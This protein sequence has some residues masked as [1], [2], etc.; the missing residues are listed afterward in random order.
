MPSQGLSC[1]RQ[2]E[3]TPNDRVAVLC[4]QTIIRAL[5]P[6]ESDYTYFRGVHRTPRAAYVR[7]RLCLPARLIAALKTDHY[8]APGPGKGN[9]FKPSAH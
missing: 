1:S 5:V 6:V 8:H 4:H 7:A 2:I 3:N 9:V